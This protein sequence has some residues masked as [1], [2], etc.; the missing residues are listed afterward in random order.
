MTRVLLV[1][2]VMVGSAVACRAEQPAANPE[3]LIRFTLSPAP[4][5]R[6]ALR[7][8][9]L[10]ELKEMNPGNPVQAYMRCMLE[11]Q[12]FF[13]DKE[14]YERRE[15][16]LAMPIQEMPTQEFPDDGRVALSQVDR[17]ARLD[18]ADWQVLQKLK[19]DGL[20]LLLP[21]VQAMRSLARA[22]QVR[23]RAEVARGRFD[24]AI[25]TAQTMFAMSRHMAEHPCLISDLVGI[26][27]AFIAVVPMEEMLS[28]PGCP[29]LY[30]AFTTLP[31]P[32][33]TLEKAMEG[34]RIIVSSVY[35]DLDESSPMSADQ[36]KKFVASLDPLFQS[37]DGKVRKPGER[38]RDWLDAR[39]K[40]EKAVG[41][42]R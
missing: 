31:N 26:A 42:A 11:Q 36:L 32:L 30:W 10:P 29:N 39:T 17:A 5:P 24:D 37:T 35:R 4:I 14:A 40:D 22:L 16:L 2:A 1:L 41:A 15:K 28:Q 13:F 19:S 38:V 6:P 33:I 34:E 3:T 8:R 20:N 12:G 18:N 7:Y 27:I 9:L 23:F 25:R 21:E